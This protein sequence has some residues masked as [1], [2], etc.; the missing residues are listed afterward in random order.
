MLDSIWFN[1]ILC[2]WWGS[3]KTGKLFST[4]F[5]QFFR[6][7]YTNFLQFFLLFLA[8]YFFAI[9]CLIFAQFFM[10]IL[11]IFLL[12]FS[13]IFQNY[14]HNV[15][16]ISSMVVPNI[17]QLFPQIL[18][19]L[20]PIFCNVFPEILFG[21]YKTSKRQKDSKILK[22]THFEVLLTKIQNEIIFFTHLR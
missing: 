1:G 8:Q 13:T 15:Y 5:E 3:L 14:F 11:C 18:H 17:L 21:S 16:A 22:I 7:L 4:N 10:Q 9:F 12:N 20:Y 19:T 2:P 6:N